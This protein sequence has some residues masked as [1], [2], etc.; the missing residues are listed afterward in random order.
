METII[1]I[2]ILGGV[3]GLMWLAVKRAKGSGGGGDYGSDG[4][5]VFD[6]GSSDSSSCDGGGGDSGG[7]DC[8]GGD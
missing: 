3:G 1:G 2:A 7:G 5:Y 8:G 6:S 4:T